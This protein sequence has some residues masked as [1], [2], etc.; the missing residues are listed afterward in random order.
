MYCLGPSVFGA[1][2]KGLVRSPFGA[3]VFAGAAVLVFLGMAAP[4]LADDPPRAAPAPRGLPAAPNGSNYD[5]IITFAQDSARDLGALRQ[6][7]RDVAAA[8]N[9]TGAQIST[10]A[11]LTQKPSAVR[12]RL[13]REALRLSASARIPSDTT[14]PAPVRE[15]ADEMRQLRVDLKQQYAAL[16]TQ[17]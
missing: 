16:E 11:A 4:A 15:A 6:H 9:E 17:A 1:V 2:G 3:A 10:L 8:R 7:A 13:E 14:L 12:D 5:Q